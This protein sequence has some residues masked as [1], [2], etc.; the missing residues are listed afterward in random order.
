MIY[1]ALMNDHRK[2]EALL[3][4]LVNLNENDNAERR[5]L[6]YQIH[7]ELI[8]HAR[9]EEAVFYNSI[10]A[11]NTAQDLV[12][13]SFEEHM[14]AEALLRTLEAADTIDVEFIST[15]RKLKEAV[16]HHIQEEEARIIPVAK[17]LFTD[18]EAVVMAEAFE[19]M[20]PQVLDEGILQSTLDMIA[21]MMPTRLAAPLRTFSLKA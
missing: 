13:H 6:I 17:H 14:E 20:K 21:N 11:I 10:R 19:Q 16:S 5:N 4:R 8:P 7:H 3:V 15:A 18:D 12:W 9:A 1:D 2:V